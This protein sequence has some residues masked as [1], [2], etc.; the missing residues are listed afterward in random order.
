MNRSKGLGYAWVS[1]L[2]FLSACTQSDLVLT[3]RVKAKI[4]VDEQLRTSHIEVATHDGVVTLT[5]DIDSQDAKARAIALAKDIKGVRDVTDMIAV[6]TE[7]GNGDA[8]DPNRTIGVTIDDAGT[9]LRVKGR[10]LDD[11]IVKAYR[12]DVDTRDGVVFLTGTVGSDREKDQAIKLARET[13]GVKD[14]QANLTIGKG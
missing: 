13:R 5:G 9:T 7:A 14:V 11:P 8:P 1:A 6:K 10:L 12:I 4:A 2:I 3:A